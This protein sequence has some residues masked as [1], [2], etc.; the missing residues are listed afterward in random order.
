MWKTASLLI[1]FVL[2]LATLGLVMLASASGV[3]GE[4][5]FQ[6]SSHFLI[7]Q[8][9]WF[10]L[11]GV[12]GFL[13]ARVDYH[14]LRWFAIPAVAFVAILLVMCLIPGVGL[15]INGSRRWLGAGFANIQPSEFAKLAVILFLAWWI[16]RNERRVTTLRDGVVIPM[17]VLGLLLGLIFFEPD[18]G[19]TILIGMVGMAMLF[20]GGTRLGYLAIIGVGGVIFFA[21]AIAHNELRWR[22]F[23]AFLHPDRYA[24]HEAFQL[25]QGI[26]AFVSGGAGGAGLG[27]GMQK[28]HYLPEAHTDFILPIIAEELGIGGSMAVVA[29]FFGVFICGMTIV[30]YAPDTFGRL[31]AF[32]ITLMITS[33]ALINIGVVTGCLPTKGLALPFISYGGSSLLASGLMIGVLI[34]VALHA[35]G[36]IDD[37]DTRQIKDRLRRA[38]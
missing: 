28:L 21:L 2:I 19:T 26:Y 3:H 33:Q 24:E 8:A 6:D 5:R 20:F 14:R 23:M 22:R 30:A 12:G 17:A 35:G 31:L 18:Y 25:L 10:V 38:M 27:Q 34:N 15:S 13:A 1:C 11:A 29:L 32:G 37:E 7:R 16:K 36:L 4:A 9:A